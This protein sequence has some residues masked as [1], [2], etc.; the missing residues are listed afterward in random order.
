MLSIYDLSLDEIINED[1]TS[2]IKKYTNEDIY[3]YILNKYSY[4]VNNHEIDSLFVL[5]SFISNIC[6]YYKTNIE[7]YYLG[8]INLSN[9]TYVSCARKASSYKTL[10]DLIE[11]T[12]QSNCTYRIFNKIRKYTNSKEYSFILI[13][14]ILD[15]LYERHALSYVDITVIIGEIFNNVDLEDK[16]ISSPIKSDIILTLDMLKENK[17]FTQSII[18]KNKLIRLTSL[19]IELYEIYRELKNNFEKMKV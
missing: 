9:L 8:N 15:L 4:Y 11:T 19:G 12:I 14:N 5:G 7:A 3:N 6:G 16:N 2:I 13:Y 17:I 18:G 1:I 10:S